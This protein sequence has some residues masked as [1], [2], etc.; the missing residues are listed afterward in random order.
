MF[1]IIYAVY[2]KNRRCILRAY[3]WSFTI[4]RITGAFFSLLFPV[5]I[6]YFVFQH[7]VSEKFIKYVGTDN[8]L[9]YIVIGQALDILAFAT[10]MNVGRCLIT[11]IREG[12]LEPFITSSASRIQYFIGAYLEQFVRSMIEYILIC[13]IGFLLGVRL[14]LEKIGSFVFIVILSSISFFSVSILISTV[15]VYTRDT[16]LVQN[17]FMIFM[18]CVCGVVFPIEYL[19]YPL[20]VLA[21]FFPLTPTLSLFRNV[22][23]LNYNIYDCFHQIV[24]IFVL[25]IVYFY[26]G[27]TG[28]RRIETKL[29][30]D[31]FS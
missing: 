30:E 4:S 8:Y 6:Y 23:L 19:P 1:Q 20:E 10:L 2:K 26:V 29:I 15:M 31:V 12:T 9:S 27:Y 3:P 11:E 13:I 21:N 28:F 18:E 16:Y 17:T 14:P 25:S 5:L 7:R 24:H 22:A